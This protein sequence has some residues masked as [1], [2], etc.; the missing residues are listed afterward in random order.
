[1]HRVDLVLNRLVRLRR[2]VSREQQLFQS[3]LVRIRINELISRR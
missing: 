3:R 2:N 1:M